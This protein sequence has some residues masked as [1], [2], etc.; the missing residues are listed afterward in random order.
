MDREKL[1]KA[2][3]GWIYMPW[4][5]KWSIGYDDDSGKWSINHGYN[6][7]FIDHGLIHVSGA[8]KLNWIN[9]FKL[10]FYVDHLAGKGDLHLWD[11]NKAGPFMINIHS[12]GIRYKPINSKMRKDLKNK[13]K[14]R[15][16]KVKSSPYR[17]AF[18][19]DDEVSWGH[20]VHPCMWRVIENK[21]LYNNW[22]CEIY[23]SEK[24]SRQLKPTTYDAYW[25]KLEYWSLKEF[26]VSPL[27]DQWTFNDSYWCNFIGELV[28]HSNELD[29]DTPCGIVGAQGPSPF[30]GYDYS[31]LMK[32][33]QFIEAYDIG[34]SQAIIRS[35]NKH[36]SKP[37]VTTHFHKNVSDSVWQLWYYLAH[38]N[39]G[40]IGWVDNWFDQ[41]TGKPKAWHQKLAPHYMEAGEKL[42]QRL[43][44][45]DWIHN[46][47]AIYYNHASLQLGWILDSEPHRGTWRNRNND[48]N[49]GSA[50]LVRKAWVNMLRDS[51]LQFDFI[52]YCDVIQSGI[53]NKYKVLILPATLCLSDVEADR[54]KDFCRAGGKVIADYAPG[55]WD[56]HGK[57]RRNGGALDAMFSVKHDPNLRASNIFQKQ[58]W[59]EVDQ[60]KNYNQPSM[61][62]FLSNQNSSIRH[63]NGYN[64]AIRN[65]GV[66]H[67]NPFGH[68]RA[69]L[70]NQSPQWYNAY[71]ESSAS[72]AKKRGVFIKHVFAAGIKPL[73][74][75]K[76]DLEDCHKLKATF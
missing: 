59:V 28:K 16:S 73:V 11:G 35:F 17:A 58:L 56:Q 69:V 67:I 62:Q 64:I 43:R 68:G 30:G 53:P 7:A 33:V 45:A 9:K 60:D 5:W 13:I 49:I 72:E 1:F 50:H 3:P 48:H 15:I 31:K 2:W 27:M 19:L 42:G 52:S 70:M 32:K 55:L 57:G 4:T 29:P 76:G 41:K 66:E 74:T 75:L 36:N 61:T 21:D 10:R 12:P 46:Q 44:G 20:F 6:G 24:G 51:G 18:A 40:V 26:D 39:C 63:K 54:I 8:N 65:M 14:D 34:D 25:P 38:G 71:R 23:G 37:V 22:L 47:I